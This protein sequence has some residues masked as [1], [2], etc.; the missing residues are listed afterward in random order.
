MNELS[1]SNIAKSLTWAANVEIR[2]HVAALPHEVL[3]QQSELGNYEG[4]GVVPFSN[5]Q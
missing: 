5:R 4:V 2:Y 3:P 1:V